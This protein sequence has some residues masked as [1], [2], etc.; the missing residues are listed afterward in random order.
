MLRAVL[1]LRKG[2]PDA[3]QALLDTV[4]PFC[5]KK[6]VRPDQPHVVADGADA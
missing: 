4:A 5:L 1:V 6:Y 3:Q 2:D